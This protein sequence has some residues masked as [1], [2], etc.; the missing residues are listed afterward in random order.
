LLGKIVAAGNYLQ[1]FISNKAITS[2]V[3]REILKRG[4]KYGTSTLYTGKKVIVEFGSPN[5]AKEFHAGH[6]RS[7]IIGSFLANLHEACGWEVIRMNYLGDWGTQFGL[8]AVGYELFGDTKDLERDPIQHLCEV[9]VK[10]NKLKDV[11]MAED[12]KKHGVPWPPPERKKKKKGASCKTEEKPEDFLSA[13]EAETV[14]PDEK[15]K[16]KPQ[17]NIQ[18]RAREFFHRMEVGYFPLQSS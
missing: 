8:L 11:E 7:T 4:S 3:L 6:L 2:L 15:E 14:T 1:F 17:S 13:N 12:A 16:Y 10:A 18:N 9:Y 5:I